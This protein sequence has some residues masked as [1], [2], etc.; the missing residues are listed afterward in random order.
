M[1]IGLGVALLRNPAPTLRRGVHLLPANDH[2]LAVAEA[3]GFDTA[4]TRFS[5]RDVEPARDQYRWQ[6]PD[7]LVNGAAFYNLDLVVR[8]DQPPAWAGAAAP[9]LN[10]P[11]TDLDD[12]ARFAGALAARYQGR[13]AAYIVWNEPN[14]AVNWG[15]Q[16]PD[17][18]GYVAL[19]KA[20]Y[21]A[22]KAADPDA[23]VISAGL[24]STNQQDASALDDRLFLQAMYSA[25]AA[26][27]FDALGAHPYG[28]GQPPNDPR[29]AHDGLNLARVL[30]LHEVMLKA[31]D[32]KKPVWATEF[33]WTVDAAGPAVMLSQ[34]AEYTAAAFGQ[35]TLDWPWLQL[36]A[37]SNLGGEGQP[38]AAGYSLLDAN[39]DPRPV[40][41]A[42]QKANGL[43]PPRLP[44]S[45]GSLTPDY[46]VAL[47]SDV[48]IQL[49]AGGAEPAPQSRD[50]Q[51]IVYVPDPG[52]RPWRMTMQVMQSGVS[53]PTVSVNGT[54]LTP[55]APP[56]DGNGQWV[57]ATWTAPAVLL[58]LGPNEIR[59]A[60]DS[61]Q[62]AAPA[63]QIKDIVLIR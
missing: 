40:F 12:Y 2:T 23:L 55:T 16:P 47:A 38:D 17:P 20:A 29:G 53:A 13:I 15:G 30:D 37:V 36:L 59:V 50:W 41:T 33:G 63:L 57:T 32:S 6:T 4:V 26:P 60:L 10:T 45:A 21:T 35:A 18:A 8:L 24:A 48:V 52:T 28:F 49:G 19:L 7:E 25:G 22:I 43:L 5:W 27:Y 9:A 1:I 61:N 46:R 3:G 44:R 31:G 62:P 51:G 58:R 14:L 54:P 39:G 56:A 11:P 42:L 34:Q